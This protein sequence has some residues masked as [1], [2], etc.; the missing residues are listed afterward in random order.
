MFEIKRLNDHETS[1]TVYRVDENEK[2][3]N[4]IFSRVFLN[5]EKKEI[6]L[7]GV[8]G[9]DIFHVKGSVDKGIK[10]SVIGGPGKDS[11]IDAS[12]VSGWGH[13]TKFY[14]NPENNISTS[15]ETK[16]HLSK[17]PSINRYEY[18]IFKYD[19]RSVKTILY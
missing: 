8:G 11:L 2:A 15:A 7:Y 18:E 9:K 1:V 4:P 19:S 10:V 5:Q 16:V 6:K 3:Q 13:K 17:S 12:Y 14:H